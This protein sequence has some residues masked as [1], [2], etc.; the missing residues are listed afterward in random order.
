MLPR[1]FAIL[2]CLAGLQAF[3]SA[4][5][6]KRQEKS[7]H[8]QVSVTDDQTLEFGSFVLKGEDL[9][10]R[11]RSKGRRSIVISGNACLLCGKTRFMARNIEA[12]WKNPD[13]MYFRLQGDIEIQNISGQLRMYA[14]QAAL[15]HD[16]HGTHLVLQ[17]LRRGPVTLLSTSD[18]KTTELVADKIDV[19]SKDAKTFRVEP[20]DLVSFDERETRLTDRI[21]F[22]AS[23]PSE[24]DIFNRISKMEFE[25]PSRRSSS[26]HS[27]KISKTEFLQLLK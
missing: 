23:A 19:Y 11:L 13:E 6:I 14:Q 12:S 24:Y 16:Q 8:D 2:V 18:Q 26:D 20:T 3:C 22:E 25:I 7:E 5:E 9:K 21:L 4:E 15:F 10:V 17:N 1:F 27:Q